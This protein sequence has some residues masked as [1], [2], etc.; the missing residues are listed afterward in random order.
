MGSR[1][2]KGI[3]PETGRWR[4]TA[5]AIRNSRGDAV[6]QTRRLA[7]SD[8]IHGPMDGS[9]SSVALR[10]PP[11]LQGRRIPCDHSPGLTQQFPPPVR[12]FSMRF[13]PEQRHFR[14][15]GWLRATLVS[16]RRREARSAGDPKRRRERM[17]RG[18]AVRTGG[19]DRIRWPREGRPAGVEGRGGY[20]GRSRTASSGSLPA[21]GAAVRPEYGH[22]TQASGKPA[23]R[24]VCLS[25]KRYSLI[26]SGRRPGRSATPPT[27][28]RLRGRERRASGA[29]NDPSP[30]P[31]RSHPAARP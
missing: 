28:G 8:P 26:S 16:S 10:E 25:P 6:R 31:A 5:A 29:E 27:T 3:F 12:C 4:T 21:G 22:P 13:P 30:S 9:P 1:A 11:S 14:A 18:L 24:S 20:P 19:P 2:V 23:A 17:E 7:I 15:A